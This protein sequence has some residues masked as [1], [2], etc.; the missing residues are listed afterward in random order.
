[1]DLYPWIVYVHVAGALIFVLGH[2]VSIAVAFKLR[3]ERETGRIKALLDLSAWS[4]SLFYAGILLLLAAGIWAGFTPGID[5]SWWGSAWIWAALAT[6]IVTMF[7]MY[8]MGSAHYKKVR[9]IVDAMAEGSE[10]VSQDQLAE[11]LAGPRAWVLAVFGFVALF[12]ILYLM[13]F[14]PF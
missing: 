10:A 2:G 11:L 7:V 8:G 3:G 12:F 14:K 9:T 1:M 13:L 5:G 6:F 4:F